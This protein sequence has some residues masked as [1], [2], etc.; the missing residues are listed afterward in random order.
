MSRDGK[1]TKKSKACTT[2]TGNCPVMDR[3]A[4]DEGESMTRQD[5]SFAPVFS[6]QEATTPLFASKR[7]HDEARGTR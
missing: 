2:R 7:A 1:A 4:R 6:F 3:R 5:Y